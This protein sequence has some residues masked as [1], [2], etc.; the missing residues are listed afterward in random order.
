[1]SIASRD[2]PGLMSIKS[3]HLSFENVDGCVPS[4]RAQGWGN[5]SNVFLAMTL[6]MKADSGSGCYRPIFINFGRFNV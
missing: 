6:A 2:G 5:P 1:V 4:Q 3:P